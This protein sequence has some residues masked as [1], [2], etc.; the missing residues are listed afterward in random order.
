MVIHT[1]AG[2]RTGVARGV[3]EDG[4]LRVEID[5]EIHYMHGGEVSLR[6]Q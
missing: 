2:Q 5:G 3:S 6:L 4:A 1:G